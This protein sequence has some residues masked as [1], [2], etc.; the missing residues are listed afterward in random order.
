M[1]KLY[2]L[3]GETAETDFFSNN[4]I[5]IEVI[6]GCKVKEFDTEAEQKAYYQGLQDMNGYLTYNSL[7]LKEF[8]KI[9]ND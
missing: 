8:E 1:Y 4:E 6:D 9:Q 7:T 5:T 3:F 2:I